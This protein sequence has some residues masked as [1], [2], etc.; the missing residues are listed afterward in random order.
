MLIIG[1]ETAPDGKGITICG[2][3][4]IPKN[5]IKNYDTIFLVHLFLYI[6]I[7][8]SFFFYLSYS[9]IIITLAKKK[10][11]HILFFFL[12]LALF[13]VPFFFCVSHAHRITQLLQRQ[14]NFS[15]VFSYPMILKLLRP[16]SCIYQ[17]VL[18]NRK[19]WQCLTY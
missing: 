14:L 3:F 4:S 17:P 12:S 2:D 11:K 10:K 15:M 7:Y 6:K 16:I 9:S 5:S 13:V 8:I 18:V 19:Q 1:E